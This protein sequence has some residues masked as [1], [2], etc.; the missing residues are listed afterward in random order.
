M[1]SEL[2]L[3][4]TSLSVA[5]D[6]LAKLKDLLPEAF[7]EN[8]IDFEKLRQALG[9]Q[10]EI[11]RERYGLG[12]AGRSEAVRTLMAPGSGTLR[13]CPAE[14]VNFD[15]TENLIIE[16]DNLEVLKLLQKSYYGKVKLIYI[17]PPYNTGNDFIY[18]DDFRDTLKAYQR[19]TGQID[20]E[21]NATS[22]QQDRSGRI[23]SS[24]LNMMYPRL[25]LARNLLR[26]DGV[27][28]VSIDD[29]EVADLSS[30]LNETFGEENLVGRICWKN[31]TDN[32][33]TLINSEHEYI[34]CYAKNRKMLPQAWK[35]ADSEAKE[36]LMEQYRQLKEAGLSCEE[37]QGGIR[38][39]ITDNEELV[40]FLTRY[41]HVDENG[42][43]TGSESVHNTKPDGYDFEI[44]HPITNKPM[45]KPANG[46]RFPYETYKE[47]ERAGSIIFGEDENRIIK[48]KKYLSDYEDT[49]RSVIT[50]DGRLGSYDLARLFT[51]KKVFDNPKPVDLLRRIFSF[52]SDK[53]SIIL[54][55]F[56]GAGTSGE[57]VIRLN[58][59]DGGSRRFV[60]VQLPE[61]AGKGEYSNI[62]DVTRERVR[63]VI[64]RVKQKR[65]ER[66][67][68]P[69]LIAEDIKSV[70]LGFRALRLDASNFRLWD[71]EKAPIEADQ[72]ARQL[73]LYADNLVPGRSEQDVLFEL[74]LKSGLPLSVRIEST[75]LGPQSGFMVVHDGQK[76]V[77]C[78]SNPIHG[79]TLTAICACKPAQVICLDVAF[80]GQDDL[81]ANTVLQMR[82][83][84]IRFQTA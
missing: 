43:Y 66:L 19:Y 29:I 63:R 59:A 69:G 50:M 23:H 1:S 40:G 48:I 28:F 30:L 22:S 74:I 3:P 32:N 16:G 7:T 38:T 8:R 81:K 9:D 75:S 41:K 25:H 67:K 31:V 18:A 82:D 21:G 53:D 54:D 46:Y 11:G 84:G 4:L 62:A 56:A 68:Q 71:S 77:F 34:L 42:V 79:D 72:L 52:A 35:S 27:I 83:A 14:S 55:F 51:G 64:A 58:E 78:L 47:M 39:F 12:W 70:D 24:W 5:N 20:D 13:P 65:E 17:D 61:Q 6:R 76:H 60:L 36:I 45:R 80:A 37:I 49:F 33:P 2:R 44:F 10:V 26:E 57:A 73:A 15:A